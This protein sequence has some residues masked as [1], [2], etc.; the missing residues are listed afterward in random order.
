MLRE[1]LTIFT[2][3]ILL[4][5]GL[6]VWIVKRS[7]QQERDLDLLEQA[8]KFYVDNAGK[9]AAVIL[10]RPNP[11]PEKIQ[12]LLR[13]HIDGRLKDPEQKQTLLEWAKSTALDKTLPRDER[14]VAYTLV[15]AIGA[16]RKLPDHKRPKPWWKI[17]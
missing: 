4:L 14:G 13:A 15:G 17:W 6:Q 16:V 9:G 5:I 7:F 11:V 3:I 10:N 12:P 8:F 1:I 2:P